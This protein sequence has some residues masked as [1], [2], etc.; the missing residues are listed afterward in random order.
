[1]VQLIQKIW[2]IPSPFIATLMLG[3]FSKGGTFRSLLHNGHDVKSFQWLQLCK[4]VWG[5]ILNHWNLSSAI[6][7]NNHWT[8]FF[9]NYLLYSKRKKNLLEKTLVLHSLNVRIQVCEQHSIFFY[10]ASSHLPHTVHACQVALSSPQPITFM[11]T[12]SPSHL[13]VVRSWDSGQGH[14]PTV[15]LA[16][17]C[18]AVGRVGGWGPPYMGPRGLEVWTQKKPLQMH[19]INRTN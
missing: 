3:I 5:L 7:V 6:C 13:H 17:W 2:C 14:G 9:G 8:F 18:L 10:P 16:R 15:L 11:F 19:S 1:M 12:S 4:P